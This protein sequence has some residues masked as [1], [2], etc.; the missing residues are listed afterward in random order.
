[1]A[2]AAWQV[3]TDGPRRLT[4]GGIELETV[5]E[6][7]IERDIGLIDPGLLVI[8]R[9]LHVE[10]G[11]LDLLCV[12]VQGRATV[13]EIKRGKLIRETVAQGLDYAASIALMPVAA[14]RERIGAYLKPLPVHPGLATLLDVSSDGQPR[15]VPW[16]SSV[17]ALIRACTA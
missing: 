5:L 8:Q 2:L 12:D 10:G 16:S 11:I 7:W 9:Q 17:S 1:M 3:S 14:L 4:P 15:E 13:I 6:G